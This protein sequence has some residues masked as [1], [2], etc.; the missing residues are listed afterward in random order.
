[1]EA[2]VF[3][4]IALLIEHAD[5]ALDKREINDHIWPNRPVTDAALSQLLRKARRALGDS[6][7]TQKAIRTVHGRGLQW[8]AP[9][10][11]TPE[12]AATTPP[13]PPVPA[14]A[15]TPTDAG[16]TAL[17]PTTPEKG[18]AL[19]G[20]PGWQHAAAALAIALA[21]VSAWWFLAAS[22]PP[23]GAIR[24]AITPTDD[25]TG[26]T[27]LAWVRRGLPGLI[28]G[29]IS[30][31][32]NTEV[33]TTDDLALPPPIA[34]TGGEPQ[35]RAWRDALGATHLLSSELRRLGPLYELE[36][37]LLPLAGGPGY[38]DV[39]RGDNP[40]ALAA[41]V[42]ARTQVRLHR[43]DG[44]ERADAGISDPFVAEVYARGVDAQGRGD[45]ASAR[46]YFEICL[47]HYPGLL[48]PRLQLAIAEGV[49]GRLEASQ[50]QAQRLAE[51]ALAR[52]ETELHARAL[53]Q[54]ARIEHQRG[55]AEAAARQLDAAMARLPATGHDLLR[56]DLLVARGVIANEQGRWQPAH[57]DFND[58]LTQ[59]RAIGDRRR[60]ALALLN[61]AVVE[62]DR[63]DTEAIVATLRAG[64]DAARSAGDGALE[65]SALL[66]LAG[67]ENN[68]GRPL[69][70][71]TLLRQSAQQA[72]GRSDPAM[73]LFS[74]IGLTR[75]TGAFDRF[76]DA[77][78]YADAA[79][80]IARDS[81]NPLWQA[82][83]LWA[84]ASLA[85]RQG[86]WQAA[87]TGLDQAFALLSGGGMS[88][89]AVQVAAEMAD[90]ATRRNDLAGAEHAAQ[91][92][93]TLI[94]ANHAPA[95]RLD[96]FLPLIDAQVRYLRGEQQD[97]IDDLR[98]QLAQQGQARDPMT[99][100]AH[101]QLARWLLDHGQAADLVE[102]PIWTDWLRHQPD[103]ALL[104]IEALR[105]VG[106][107]DQAD[108]EQ[109]RLTA[110]TRSPELALD[111]S[112]LPAQ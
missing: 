80:R 107:N 56:I 89:I 98:Q 111:A 50:A 7:D 84:Q 25:R 61:L 87:T 38:R 40:S 110:L 83:A 82:E 97:A 34:E 96:A 24:L 54:L 60:E 79:L 43:R 68:A 67:A 26:E 5:R 64:L 9:R 31:Q 8:V 73:Y 29:L 28:A 3:D 33:S 41:D 78:A 58:A 32:D 94:A 12:P 6:G 105:A 63:G 66:N 62:V 106:R 57:D 74:L 108:D 91:S 112:L 30:R 14:P 11:A 17:S 19:R 85:G 37:R 86:D 46:K 44:G 59:A 16:S 71:L 4:L 76:Q 81:G 55:N 13:A 47:D 101:R 93:R 90:I 109:A 27:E 22:Q 52:G 35:R 18:P 48:Q 21:A 104:Y 65:M 39:L 51:E 75:I 49:A 2:K 72:L 23:A 102:Q 20:R 100:V 99:A 77:Q 88:R 36:V 95:Q 92:S 69:H 10:E 103:V 53:R 1:M 15:T 45:H 42:A 70:A